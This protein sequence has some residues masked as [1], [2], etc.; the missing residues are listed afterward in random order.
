MII[1]ENIGLENIV[2]LEPDRSM[3]AGTR[4]G[5]VEPARSPSAT[6]VRSM[7][8]Q[9]SMS[10]K[11]VTLVSTLLAGSTSVLALVLSAY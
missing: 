2:T 9:G 5:P 4:P 6:A 10:G 1:I 7:S 8:V 3:W 11:T